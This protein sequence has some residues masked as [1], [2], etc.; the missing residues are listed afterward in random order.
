MGAFE[1]IFAVHAETNAE[2]VLVGLEVKVGGAALD[3]IQQHLVDELDDRRVVALGVVAAGLGLVIVAGFGVQCIEALVVAAGVEGFSRSESAVD[4]ALELLLVDQDRLDGGACRELDLLDGASVGGV[5]D[6]EEQSVAALVQ[7]QHAVLGDQLLADGFD[8]GAA[9]VEGVDL[10]QG[11][12]ELDAVGGGDRCAADHLLFEQPAH[13][14]LLG[15]GRLVQ[16]PAGV[17]LAQGAVHHEAAGDAGDA[18]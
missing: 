14:R 17:S 12:A 3:G 13:H 7:R 11:Y 16:S 1:T 15:L 18:N 9:E 5:A 6:A 2:V 8:R 4:R 10:E